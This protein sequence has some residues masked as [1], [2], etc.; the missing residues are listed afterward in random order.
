[1]GKSVFD[2]NDTFVNVTFYGVVFVGKM[3]HRAVLSP[4]LE[5]DEESVFD[6]QFS[7]RFAAELVEL[8]V[9]FLYDFE[10]IEKGLSFDTEKTFELCVTERQSFLYVFR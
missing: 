8:F 7:G 3:F 6:K 4:V 5:H 1:M 9:G 10:H 2:P